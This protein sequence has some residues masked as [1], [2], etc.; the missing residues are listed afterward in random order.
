MAHQQFNRE[1][2]IQ[3]A[4][5]LSCGYRQGE[6]AEKLGV[7]RSNVNKEI[8]RNKDEDGIY[9]GISAHRRYLR[10]RKE[11]KKKFGKIRN[12]ENLE[13][14]I[15]GRINKYWSPEQI[16]GR[17]RK[18][19]AIVISHETIYKYIYEEK[20][21]LIKFLRHQKN[22]YRKKRGSHAR[23]KLNKAS[24]VRTIEER[25]KE[26]EERKRIGDWEDDTIIGKDRKQRIWTC[27]E[28]KSGYGMAE[29]LETVTAEIMNQKNTCSF[30][31]IPKNKRLTLTRDNGLEFGD[32]DRDLERKTGLEVYRAHQYHSWERGSN[33]NWNGLLRQFFPSG[34]YFASI[35]QT[36]VE[37]AVKLLNSRPRKR[38]GY[39]TPQEVFNRCGDSD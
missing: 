29:K 1:T 25:P 33:E 39:A 20:P 16:V 34:S 35:N 8:Q 27:V 5:L 18:T 37:R 10:R 4:T 26:V 21:E 12:D 23:M 9:R 17:L 6:A 3:L 36:D 38:L 15:V 7:D 19:S 32:Y 24:K 30:K 22:K 13:R 2:R 14:H 28:R 11:S 31:N